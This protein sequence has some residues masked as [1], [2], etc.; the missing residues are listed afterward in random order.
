MASGQTSGNEQGAMVDRVDRQLATPF[1]SALSG[2]DGTLTEAGIL[3]LTPFYLYDPGEIP[4]PTAT[5]GQRAQFVRSTVAVSA[6]FS[7][8]AQTATVEVWRVFLDEKGQK[9]LKGHTPLTFVGGSSARAG[10]Y[11]APEQYVAA[12]GAVELRFAVVTWAGAAG[13][14]AIRAGSV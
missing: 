13:T 12:M 11:W 7:D 6:I 14:L 2:V 4:G 1:R 10:A 5:A 8:A 3:A 9:K